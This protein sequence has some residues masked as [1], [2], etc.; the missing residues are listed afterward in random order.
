M[1][2]VFTGLVCLALAL[3]GTQGAAQDKAPVVVEPSSPW[4]VDFAEAR[5]RA[6][7]LFGEGDDKTILFLEQIAPSDSPRWIVAGPVAE[8]LDSGNTLSVQFGP[9]IPAWEMK[10]EKG[11][12]LGRFGRAHRARS[13]FPPRSPDKGEIAD[14]TESDAGTAQAPG[15]RTLDIALGKSIEWIELKR[16]SRP[17]QRLNTGEMGQLFT[18]LNTCMTD[19]VRTWGV[20]M[21]AHK[22]RAT[23]PRPLNLEQIAARIQ[24]Y[25]PSKALNWGKQ[26][27]L[28]IR[29]MVDKTGSITGCKITNITMAEDFDDRPCA[30]FAKIGRFE[31]A[32][33]VDG[34]P[35][36]SFYVSSIIY[37]M[38]EG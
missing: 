26:A 14:A 15:L 38:S 18:I 25:Y 2:R 6:V 31:P 30:E 29:V 23:A 12:T 20:D 16:G 1:R 22:K 32:R 37:R 17:P 24:K 13:M 33:D 36:D 11:T 4:Q 5:C 7:R 19:L 28:S 8:E 35:M 21:E 27:D 3:A 34:N 10:V 9:A